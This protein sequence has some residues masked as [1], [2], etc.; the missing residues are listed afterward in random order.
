VA[1]R[2]YVNEEHFF[3]EILAATNETG[4]NMSDLKGSEMPQLKRRINVYNNINVHP[5]FT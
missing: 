4:E 1:E 5:C 3:S 2:Y